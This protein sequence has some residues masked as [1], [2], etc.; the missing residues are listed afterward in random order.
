M[1]P[2]I[3]VVTDYKKFLAHLMR[4][5]PDVFYYL[6]PEACKEIR[7]VNLPQNRDIVMYFDVIDEFGN[8]YLHPSFV[9]EMLNTPLEFKSPIMVNTST[10]FGLFPESHDLTLNNLTR[11]C[12]L[13][14]IGLHIPEIIFQWN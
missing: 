6:R 9:P 12:L 14:K 4:P 10:P 11:Y 3:Q 8:L 2:Q 1:Q 5:N 7:E 13:H